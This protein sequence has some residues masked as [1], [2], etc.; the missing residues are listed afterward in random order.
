MAI[1]PHPITRK[2]SAKSNTPMTIS[3]ATNLALMIQ[4][5]W[6]GCDSIRLSVPLFCSEL[7]ASK[8]N[9]I[10]SKGPRKLMKNTNEGSVPSDTV[11]SFRK[12]KELSGS[13]GFIAP[14]YS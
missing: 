12:R 5:R 4:S 8:P 13:S 6:I 7:T 9:A 14:R 2:P 10:P 11:K 3:A 1:K